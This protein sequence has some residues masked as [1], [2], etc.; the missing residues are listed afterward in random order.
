MQDTSLS[1]ALRVL[2]VDDSED[3]RDGLAMLLRTWGHVVRVA[4]DGPSA[5]VADSSF[6]PHVVILDVNLPGISGLDVARQLREQQGTTPVRLI[7]LTGL[8]CDQD[9]LKSREAGFD[10]HL[11]KPADLSE[12]R[13]L[14]NIADTASPA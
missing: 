12:L 14:L 11:T 6:H 8:S 5:L 7:A 10:A 13:Q 1:A 3:I 4:G 9:K 2:V